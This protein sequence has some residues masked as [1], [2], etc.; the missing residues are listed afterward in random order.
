MSEFE[1]NTRK[2]IIKDTGLL[3]KRVLMKEI[4]RVNASTEEKVAV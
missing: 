2:N 4:E 1:K 3:G